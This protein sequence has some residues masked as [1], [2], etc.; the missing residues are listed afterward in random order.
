VA[1][2]TTIPVFK[3]AKTVHALDCAAAVINE[4]PVSKKI[5]KFLIMPRQR[6]EGHWIDSTFPSYVSPNIPFYSFIL[7]F[8]R[9]TGIYKTF[10]EASTG[11]ADTDQRGW[12][13][14]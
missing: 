13:L 2:K 4:T 14:I 12:R 7:A 5:I 8:C 11:L 9:D 3:R 1:S 10:L 6:K